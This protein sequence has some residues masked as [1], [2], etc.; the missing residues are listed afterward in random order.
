METENDVMR[1]AE[2]FEDVTLMSLKI[3]RGALS[4]SI[5]LY[6]LEK[7][8]KQILPSAFGGSAVLPTAQFWPSLIDFGLL[9]TRTVR[10]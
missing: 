9:T 10:K 7:A 6:K 5:Y 3:D 2:S 4:Q 8:L 1:K